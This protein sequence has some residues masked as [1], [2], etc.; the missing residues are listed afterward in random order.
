MASSPKTAMPTRA[1]IGERALASPSGRRTSGRPRRRGDADVEIDV[2]A[3]E[4]LRG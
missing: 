3:L 4:H 2:A 1:P